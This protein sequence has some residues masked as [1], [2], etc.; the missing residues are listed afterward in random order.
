[1]RR[2][3]VLMLTAGVMLLAA[4]AP[5]T[6]APAV[7]PNVPPTEKPAMPTEGSATQMPGQDEMVRQSTAFLEQQFKIASDAVTVKEV[8]PMSWP[9]ASLGCPKI[10]VMYIQVITPGFQIVLDAN[11]HTFTFHTDAKDRVVLC[12]VNP[13][14]EAYPTP[15]R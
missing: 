15:E 12:K 13:P 7:P 4:C 8:T 14:D 5:V 10:G 11:G 1:M 9:D 6:P 2:P 3:F